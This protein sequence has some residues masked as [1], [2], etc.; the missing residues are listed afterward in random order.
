MS[1]QEIKRKTTGRRFVMGTSWPIESFVTREDPRVW[2][3]T[4]NLCNGTADGTETF[5][6]RKA[7]LAALA[8][9]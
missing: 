4:R 9:A 5:R 2:V 6:T 7:A 8:A 3:L 1:G